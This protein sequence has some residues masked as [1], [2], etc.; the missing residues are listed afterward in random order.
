MRK[1]NIVILFILFFT[2]CVSPHIHNYHFNQKTAAPKLK[3][4]FIVLKKILEANHPSLYWFTPKDSIDNYFNAAINSITDSLTE[5]ECRNKVASVVSKIHCGHTSV[6]F[7]KDYTKHSEEHRYPMFPLSI[8]TW[9]DTMVVV[10]SYLPKDSIF[11]RGTIIT[12]VNGRSNKQLLDSMFDIISTDGY[13]NTY[14]SQVISGNFPL[15]YRISWGLDTIYHISYLDSSGKEKMAIIHNYSPFKPKKVIVPKTTDSIKSIV[16]S[17]PIPKGLSSKQKRQARLLNL[18]SLSIDSTNSIAYMRLTT[19]ADGNLRSFFR[20]S[21]KAIKEHKAKS[22]IIDVR[23]NTGGYISTSNLFTKYIINRPFKNA[24]TLAAI[25]NHIRHPFYVRESLK[26]WFSSRLISRKMSD[27]RYHDRRVE[28][29]YFHPKTNYHFDGKVV[30]LQGGYTYSAATMF[31]ST[32]KGQDN[33]TIVGEESGGGNY[34]NT[35]TY[36]PTI[37][38]P[39]S[40]LRI[41]LPTYRMVMDAK[42]KKDGLGVQPDIPIRV[43]AQD[44]K[45]GIDVKVEKA[46]EI[47]SSE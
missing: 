11:K 2:S 20:R 21:F 25:A 36:L 38:L 39:N 6:H 34:G 14:K 16:K 1:I 41:I 47:I 46:K 44:I 10:G 22:L 5:T 32:A 37:I 35:A 12:S 26:Y 45:K 33:V 29:H 23:E 8:K 43:S 7:S 31:T 19:F 42:R 27:G 9:G 40:K 4:D 15:W 24:D 17:L 30:V 13:S 28:T 3:E 18:R